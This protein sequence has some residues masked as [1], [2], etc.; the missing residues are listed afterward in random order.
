MLFRDHSKEQQINLLLDQIEPLG[1]QR[2]IRLAITN[3]FQDPQYRNR[4]GRES[5]ELQKTVTALKHLV[6]MPAWIVD[7]DID[8]NHRQS[9]KKFLKH[10]DH[11][12]EWEVSMGEFSRAR[13]FKNIAGR[14]RNERNVYGTEIQESLGTSFSVVSLN[15]IR[16][17]KSA[18]KRGQNCLGDL[19]SGYRDSLKSRSSEFYEIC[20]N[21]RAVVWLEVCISRFGHH[22]EI[23]EIK[24]FDNDEPVL[25][26]EVLWNLCKTLDVNGDDCE[27]FI[28]RGVLSIFWKG[29]ANAND[30]FVQSTDYSVWGQPEEIVI[31]DR[32]NDVW[33]R[34]TWDGYD[35]S[36]L[37]RWKGRRCIGID[38]SGLEVMCR[39]MPEVEGLVQRCKPNAQN[40][41]TSTNPSGRIQR[42]RGRRR[43]M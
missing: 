15:S 13:G 25:P 3:H 12:Q 14:K 40:N 43:P 29:D 6:R 41:A 34:L 10:I 23:S 35:W 38:R 24:G 5:L 22:R 36:G 2:K 21:G 1:R 4:R 7:E 8:V 19:D 18:A 9:I 33:S 26:T 30:P 11:G 31:Y 42:R 37:E 27:L 17:L 28:D 32:K 20:E 16:D 39:L